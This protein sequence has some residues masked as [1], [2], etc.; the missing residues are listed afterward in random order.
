LNLDANS[1]AAFAD[2]G[3]E[4]FDGG[5]NAANHCQSGHISGSVVV[6]TNMPGVGHPGDYWTVYSCANAA[7]IAATPLT[8]HITVKDR[9]CPACTMVAG[10]ETIE[11]SFPYSDAGARCT[12]SLDGTLDTEIF[13]YGVQTTWSALVN[14]ERT[15]TYVITYRAK[16]SA[17]N[18]NDGTCKGS[19]A[20]KR[21]IVIVDTLK[22]VIALARPSQGSAH[23]KT[24]QV[25][26]RSSY[27]RHAVDTGAGL[28]PVKPALPHS[29]DDKRY[30]TSHMFGL[31]PA[32]VVGSHLT[33]LSQKTSAHTAAVTAALLS[34]LVG[35]AL[36]ALSAY[37]SLRTT[38]TTSAEM[39]SL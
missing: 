12:D 34:A 4:C 30:S 3:A 33:E 20:T 17:G 15:G 26:K 7:G 36:L 14:V 23:W 5:R 16:D 19:K 9:S 29:L 18:W 37:R 28:M 39:N 21:T 24:I 11:A 6:R 31:V 10:P 38:G 2:Q 8:R 1:D 35:F 27:E 32:Q 25:S 13:S 22:P